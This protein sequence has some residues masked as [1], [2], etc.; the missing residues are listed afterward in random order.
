M[1][2]QDVRE[3]L[4]VVSADGRRMGRVGR[5]GQT[6]FEIEHGFFFPRESLASYGDVREVAG[7]RVVMHQTREELRDAWAREEWLG[8]PDARVV[9]RRPASPDRQPPAPGGD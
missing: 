8:A 6:R 4:R 2:G 3:G 9:L 7:G 1:A 5:C